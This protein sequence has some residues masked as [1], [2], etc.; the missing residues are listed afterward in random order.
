M[1]F[2]R[3]NMVAFLNTFDSDYRRLCSHNL[4]IVG[5]Q[6]LTLAALC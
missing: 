6:R 5:L 4:L 2:Q 3:G 1:A